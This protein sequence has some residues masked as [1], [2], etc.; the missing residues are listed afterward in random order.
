MLKWETASWL[1]W[2]ISI[3]NVGGKIDVWIY[4]KGYWKTER[5]ELDPAY[6]VVYVVE[7][8]VLFASEHPLSLC[9]YVCA[10][11]AGKRCFVVSSN[12]FTVSRLRN[13]SLLH[14]FPSALPN[15]ARANNS[16]RSGQSYCI[17]DCI[18]HE[19]VGFSTVCGS[20]PLMYYMM[21]CVTYCDLQADQTYYVIDMV[22]WAGMSMYE[23]TT[24]FRFFWLNSKLVESGA[25]NDPSTYHRYSFRTLVVYN[26]DQE[27]L[28][29]AYTGPVS[30]VKDGLLF[31]NK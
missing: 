27:G 21:W 1:V 28:T 2:G 22:C 18:F 12:G 25:S 19:V 23:C 17:L 15:G 3:H 31:Y 26:C 20:I 30:Y 29:A 24:E 13:G 10:R 6:H 11:P 5:L 16:T 9:R 8:W 4:F 7:S 14:R